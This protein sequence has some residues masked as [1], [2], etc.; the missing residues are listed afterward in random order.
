MSD[1]YERA[2]PILN[3]YY[4]HFIKYLKA[5]ECH[6]IVMAEIDKIGDGRDAF[7]E[8]IEPFDWISS[9]VSFN[10]TPFRGEAV[11]GQIG[12]DVNVSR[13][14]GLSMGWR[15]VVRTIDRKRLTKP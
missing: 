6:D 3:L 13:W 11:I 8:E 7:I 2:I 1:P 5:N 9:A 14:A 15:D 10:H 12:R 4:H